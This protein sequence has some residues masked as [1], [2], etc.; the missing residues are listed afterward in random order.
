MAPRMFV[1]LPQIKPSLL[2]G[3]LWPGN[4][5]ETSNG[6][7][8]FDPASFY[9]HNEFDFGIATMFGQLPPKFFQGYRTVIPKERGEE[10]RITSAV[11]II[12][13]WSFLMCEQLQERSYNDYA[14]N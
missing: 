8:A 4:V 1:N 11:A 9:G 10:E 13:T 2:H 6:A 14:I 12:V 5:G 7:V 3:D